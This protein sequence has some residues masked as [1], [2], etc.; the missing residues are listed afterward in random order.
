[1]EVY[2][3]RSIEAAL[4]EISEG[5]FRFAKQEEL[6]DPIEGYINIY[7]AGD[8]A[9]WEGLFRNYICSLYRCMD[10]FFKGTDGDVILNKIIEKNIYRYEGK[11]RGKIYRTLAASFVNDA[12][13]QECIALLMHSVSNKTKGCSGRFLALWLTLVHFTAYNLCAQSFSDIGYINLK[14]VEEWND[15]SFHEIVEAIKAMIPENGELEEACE[16]MMEQIEEYTEAMAVFRYVREQDLQLDDRRRQVW[17]EITSNFTNR[18]VAKLQE[19]IYPG[20]MVVC[21]SKEKDNAVMWGNYADK[22]H[23]VCLVY[24]LALAGETGLVEVVSVKSGHKIIANAAPIAYK[25]DTIARNFFETLGRFDPQWLSAWLEGA[26]GEKSAYM[27]C[28]A[29]MAQ[30][31]KRYWQDFHEK[32]FTKMPAWAYENEYRLLIDDTLFNHD[33]EQCFKPAACTLKGVIFGKETPV[34]DKVRILKA[35][36]YAGTPIEHITVSHAV[37]DETQRR[38]CIRENALVGQIL[39][40]DEHL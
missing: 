33:E 2:H 38:I 6:N 40:F 37:Y 3:Y 4:L 11:E 5:A 29:D 30:W 12:S 8:R 16:Q 32:F 21:F 36:K 31:K 18:Y 9:A 19:L 17:L 14:P 20:G 24:E 22:H 15:N 39:A 1:M 13:V 34:A 25:E 7:W 26:N 23:G 27:N 10:L 28:Y 35:L